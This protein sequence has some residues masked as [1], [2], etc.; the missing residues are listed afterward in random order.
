MPPY[1]RNR[2]F[3]EQ[4]CRSEWGQRHKTAIAQTTWLGS[5][6]SEF[7]FSFWRFI[8]RLGRILSIVRHQKVL[9]RL[10][11][12]RHLRRSPTMEAVEAE[13]RS[14]CWCATLP[15]WFTTPPRI[16]RT[17][18]AWSAHS[19]RWSPRPARW[20]IEVS[21]PAS[22]PSATFSAVLIKKG[23]CGKFNSSTMTTF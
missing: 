22:R 15:R 6:N 17:P 19:P 9:R 21:T 2:V 4:R 8:W 23:P 20:S 3:N 10:H 5:T 18:A 7:S 14:W 11:L 1:V 13:R 12:L 16:C